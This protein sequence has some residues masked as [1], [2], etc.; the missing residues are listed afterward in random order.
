MDIPAYWG[1]ALRTAN[2]AGVP[3]I[4][5]GAPG[6]PGAVSLLIAPATAAHDR[7]FKQIRF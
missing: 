2:T 7:A 1:G 5:P 6:A 4:T 3:N